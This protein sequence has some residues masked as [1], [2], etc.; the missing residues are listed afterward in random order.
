[1]KVE[2]T[3]REFRYNAIALQDPNPNHTIEQVRD[4]YSTVYPE[5]LNAAI[6][7]P[8]SVGNKVVYT[9]K[10]AVGTKGAATTQAQRATVRGKVL[11]RL[12]ADI[13]RNSQPPGYRPVSNALAERVRDL[14][15]P[16]AHGAFIPAPAAMLPPIL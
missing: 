2:T 7:G 12:R 4:F 8:E 11:A 10:R 15:S 3:T 5:I 16:H 14:T 1:M 9:F 6:E 13:A